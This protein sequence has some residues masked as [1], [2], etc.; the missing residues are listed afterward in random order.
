MESPYLDS[1]CENQ[2]AKVDLKSP[3]YRPQTLKKKVFRNISKVLCTSKRALEMEWLIQNF[4]IVRSLEVTSE[5]R[6]Q[7]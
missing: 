3:K 7:N 4:L 2:C 1:I 6:W 5:L